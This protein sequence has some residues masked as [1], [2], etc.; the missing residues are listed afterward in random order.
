MAEA[1]HVD[2]D[3]RRLAEFGHKQELNRPWSGF[4]IFAISFSIISRPAGCLTSVDLAPQVDPSR[5]TK[6]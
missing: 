4:S 3:E 5:G 1:N 2:E 6:P